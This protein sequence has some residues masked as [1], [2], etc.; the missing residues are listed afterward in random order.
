MYM[1]VWVRI[2][3]C[4]HI[5]IVIYYWENT[6]LPQIRNGILISVS[7]SHLFSLLHYNSLIIN[8]ILYLKICFVRN[9]F[10]LLRVSNF[11]FF[12]IFSEDVFIVLLFFICCNFPETHPQNRK[13]SDTHTNDCITRVKLA[14]RNHSKMLTNSTQ[15]YRTIL[16][17]I[18]LDAEICKFQNI[19]C[20]PTY[21]KATQPIKRF[22]DFWFNNNFYFLIRYYLNI[23]AAMWSCG[24][25]TFAAINRYGFH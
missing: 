10:D 15:V 7:Q 22:A 6:R 19:S 4:V 23:T 25:V 18:I 14:E 8:I 20:R 13:K 1:F 12:R 17:I 16:L 24:C 3:I 9:R 2:K 11:N 5:I 21:A